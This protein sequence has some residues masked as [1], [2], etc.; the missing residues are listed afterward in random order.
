[1]TRILLVEDDLSLAMSLE[2]DLKLEGYQV[3]VARGR[4]SGDFLRPGV[5]GGPQKP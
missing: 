4:F 3:Q 5:D 1:M 2:D